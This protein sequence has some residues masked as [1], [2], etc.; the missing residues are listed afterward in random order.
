MAG[1]SLLMLQ[2]L[3]KYQFT[4]ISYYLLFINLLDFDNNYCFII[5]K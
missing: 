1:V 5:G 4:I 2:M 3:G